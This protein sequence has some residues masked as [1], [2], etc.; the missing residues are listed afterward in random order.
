MQHDTPRA[1][2]PQHHRE[3]L[4]ST[5]LVAEL[6]RR[7]M[8]DAALA[9]HD[10]QVATRYDGPAVEDLGDAGLLALARRLGAD[11]PSLD[12]TVAAAT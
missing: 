5:T 3:W 12:G 7:D 1:G 4:W 10:L 6:L 9:L 8:P 11:M 2:A